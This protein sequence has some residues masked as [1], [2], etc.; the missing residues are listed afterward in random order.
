MIIEASSVTKRFGDRDAVRDVELEVPRGICFGFLGPNGAGKTTLIRLMLGLA[1]PTLGT[2]RIRGVVVQSDPRLALARVGGIVEEPRFHEHMS[3]RQNL[4][5]WAA[6]LGDGSFGRIDK[7][8]DRVGLLKRADEAV[9]GYSLGMRQRLG[10]ARA[11]LNDPELLIL[12]EPTNGLDPA[13][14]V[15]FRD[16]MR[17][18]VEE[19]G[20]TV[21]I[22]SH[23]LDEIERTCDHVAI[24][25]RGTVVIEGEMKEL[26]QAGETGLRLEVDDEAKAGAV[27]AELDGVGEARPDPDGGL[28]LATDGSRDA[29]V[30][31]NRAL[32]EAGVGVFALSSRAQTLEQRYLEITGAGDGDV[33]EE[34]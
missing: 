6:L 1:R 32:V 3:A 25:K 17:S 12:D 34:I 15:E 33:R 11:M 4:E 23:L 2:V 20:R 28:F 30:A 31:A 24:V 22:S 5:A 7:E 21:F 9:E 19:E 13:G 14:M 8:L 10:V 16:L 18:L 29:A 26:I 27:L